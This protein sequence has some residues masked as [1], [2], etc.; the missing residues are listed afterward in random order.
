MKKV[1]I[2]LSILAMGLYLP[3][4][5]DGQTRK[6]KRQERMEQ[7][8]KDMEDFRGGMKSDRHLDSLVDS[9]A[10]VQAEDAVKNMSFVVKADYVTF[11]NGQRVSVDTGTNFIALDGERAVVQ[12]SPS[13]F[14]PGP[15]GV[16][17]V[18]VRGRATGVET[19]TDR[20]GRV[21]LSMSVTGIGINA[22]VSIYMVPGTNRVTATVSPNFNSNTVTFDGTIVPYANAGIF[23]GMSL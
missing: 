12:I 1:L 16:G 19:S 4:N 18:T 9:I 10:W 15:N 23:E 3:V 21:T 14:R 20:K 2:V 17:G 7:W 22:Q 11:R 13:Y 6:E 5:A 8:K